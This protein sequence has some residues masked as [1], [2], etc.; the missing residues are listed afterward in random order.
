[1]TTTNFKPETTNLLFSFSQ[2]RESQLNA[3]KNDGYGE[4]LIQNEAE[5]NLILKQKV[6]YSDTYQTYISL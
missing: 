1:M 3:I 4:Y 2:I 5:V 6:G